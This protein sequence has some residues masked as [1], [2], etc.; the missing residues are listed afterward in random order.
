MVL[1]T[2]LLSNSLYESTK[3]YCDVIN[4]GPHKGNKGEI[5]KLNCKRKDGAQSNE[6]QTCCCDIKCESKAS[7]RLVNVQS[8]AIFTNHKDV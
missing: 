4:D 6:P 2:P 7:T 1:L 8:I 3:P 5:R